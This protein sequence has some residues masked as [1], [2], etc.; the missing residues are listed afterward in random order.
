MAI[1]LAIK[2]GKVNRDI[3]EYYVDEES[4]I[5]DL[6]TNGN[7]KDGY[8]CTGSSAYVVNGGKLFLFSIT[9]DAWIEQ[10]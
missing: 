6:P 10:I 9:K 3:R 4:E 2:D 1:V 5:V 7:K 8:I